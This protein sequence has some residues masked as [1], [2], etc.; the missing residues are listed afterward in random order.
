MTKLVVMGGG[1]AGSVAALVAKATG[2][3]V[4]LSKRAFGATALSCGAFDIGY[5]VKEARGNG[6]SSPLS[7]HMKDIAALSVHHPYAVLEVERSFSMLNCGLASLLPALEAAGLPFAAIDLQAPN[8]GFASSQGSIHQAA[9]AAS[10]HIG[11]DWLKPLLGPI[12]VV[13]FVGDGY[14]DA[15]RVALG[16][17]HDVKTFVQNQG[18][19]MPEIRVID[20][21]F[22]GAA[23]PAL[24]AKSLDE[25][26]MQEKLLLLLQPKIQGLAGLVMPPV[27]GLE[28]HA[29]C[30]KGL[31][32]KL[33]L[34]V[35]EAV[36]HI[37]S[38][39]GVR[40]QWALDKAVKAAHIE[41]A[42][43]IVS[44]RTHGDKVTS[45]RTRSGKDL[46]TDALIVCS[47]RFIAGG[48]TCKERLEEPLLGLPVTTSMGTVDSVSS[49]ELVSEH[50]ELS[51]P[52]LTA[53]LLVDSSMRPKFEGQPV[54]ANVYAAGMVL[55]GFVAPGIFCTDGVAIA[56]ATRAALA[57]CGSTL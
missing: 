35:V 43:E 8:Y 2:A 10:A 23:P 24:L 57:A 3:Q 46:E 39:P 15:E 42:E 31:R 11:I 44:V 50:P 53:G 55:A 14:F 4:V 37:P 29:A 34:P 40:L 25:Q 19:S 28:H 49:I 9:T 47:G 20:I 26:A 33:A 54:F 7:E 51:H 38:V 16:L 45:V 21:D 36:A 5:S 30:L 13:Q 12:G 18:D 48:V 32:E 41:Q 22:P 52:L 6:P 27:L 17:T 56:T 1:L